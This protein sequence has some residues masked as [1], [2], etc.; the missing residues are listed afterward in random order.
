VSLRNELYTTLKKNR[1]AEEQ[2]ELRFS[3]D[4]TAEESLI[5]EESE[6]E[7]QRAMKRV[8]NMLTPRQ[9]EIF[10]YR[11]ILEMKLSEICEVT[12]INYQSLQN[13]MQRSLHKIRET[14]ERDGGAAVSRSLRRML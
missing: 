11:Y 10:Y 6:I 8:L 9:K 4:Y 1:N 5:A 12:G 3:I 2:V 14:I 7:R 13:L